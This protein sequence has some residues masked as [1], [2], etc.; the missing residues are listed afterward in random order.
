VTLNH[1]DITGN[2][3]DNCFPPGTITGCT[4]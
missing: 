3:P 1:T 4:G 2:T